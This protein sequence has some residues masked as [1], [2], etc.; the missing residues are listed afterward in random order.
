MPAKRSFHHFVW[1]HPVILNVQSITDSHINIRCTFT[2]CLME[3]WI[4]WQWLSSRLAYIYFY[5]VHIN[6]KLERYCSLKFSPQILQY[7][8]K[9]HAL[10]KWNCGGWFK[11]KVTLD[12]YP[13]PTLKLM[14]N[15]ICFT[16]SPDKGII[17]K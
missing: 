12:R 13:F 1:A 14:Y 9:S 10:L 8:Y 2:G 15:L 11:F 7:W 3:P 6:N 16:M 5:G 17:I 4:L